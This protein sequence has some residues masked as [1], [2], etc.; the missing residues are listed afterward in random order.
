[1]KIEEMSELELLKEY[2]KAINTIGYANKLI[3]D[4]KKVI[5]VVDKKLSELEKENKE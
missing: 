3:D 2:R 1:M 5:A 4:S